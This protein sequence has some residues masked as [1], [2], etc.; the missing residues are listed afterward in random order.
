MKNK[1][2]GTSY[3]EYQDPIG[4]KTIRLKDRFQPYITKDSTVLDFGCGAGY[5]LDSI[6]CKNKIGIDINPI[7][8]N[9]ASKKIKTFNTL[10]DVTNETID[11]IISNSTLGHLSNPE[12]ILI[13]LKSKLKVGGIIIFSIPHETI[14]FKF[15]TNDINKIFYTWS[16]MS[17]GNL[18]QNAGFEIVSIKIYKEISF[19]NETN[20]QNK[21]I[22]KLLNFFRPLYRIFR[23]ILEEL[24]ILTLGRDGNIILYSRKIK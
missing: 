17:L 14:N 16:P 12:E 6:E 18:F 23:L 21:T 7:A 1:N 24:G 5:L 22:I 15:K 11:C 9:E 2:Y 4:K 19:P 8:L 13:E 10:K 20:I 3:F